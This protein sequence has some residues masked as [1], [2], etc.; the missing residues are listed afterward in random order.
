MCWLNGFR[1]PVCIQLNEQSW[2][3]IWYH[4]IWWRV[5]TVTAADQR[6]F[7]VFFPALGNFPLYRSAFRRA[8]LD[9]WGWFGKTGLSYRAPADRSES[10]PILLWL[11]EK[12]RCNVKRENMDVHALMFLPQ[13]QQGAYVNWNHALDDGGS[14]FSSVAPVVPRTIVL[15]LGYLSNNSLQLFARLLLILQKP[16]HPLIILQKLK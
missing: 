1:I 5:F 6:L 4:S 13:H 14:L 16:F 10:S 8:N 11:S 3:I 2:E 9:W 15:L 7:P 12:W